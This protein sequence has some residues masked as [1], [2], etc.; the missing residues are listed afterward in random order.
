MVNAADASHAVCVGVCICK[1]WYF[2]ALSLCTLCPKFGY[3]RVQLTGELPHGFTVALQQFFEEQQKAKY[4]SAAKGA[5]GSDD[6][7]D[8]TGKGGKKGGGKRQYDDPVAAEH[9]RHRAVTARRLRILRHLGLSPPAG[10]PFA[11]ANA[12]CL[13]GF[14]P[15]AVQLGYV[16]PAAAQ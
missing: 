1:F 4:K 5:K 11:A 7:K 16:Q 8:M 15:I 14:G 3:V 10:S 9:A 12:A 2:D 6:L 13:D